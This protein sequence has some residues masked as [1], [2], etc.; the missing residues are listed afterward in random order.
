MRQIR[1]SGAN[2]KLGK[3][4]GM[5]DKECS[6]LW[7][8]TDKEVCVSCWVPSWKDILYIIFHRKIWLF[9]LSGETQPPVKIRTDSREWRD[10]T[11]PI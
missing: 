2:K 9:V 6:S 8:Y 11:Y 3:P 10:E 7:V 4:K 5:T 1:F